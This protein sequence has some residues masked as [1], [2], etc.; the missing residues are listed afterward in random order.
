VASGREGE[1]VR[2]Y[3]EAAA[4]DFA[5]E[6]DYLVNCTG[7]DLLEQLRLLLPAAVRDELGRR[8]GGLWER[9]PAA[10]IPI[11][12]NLE[13]EG[14]CPRLHIPGLAGLSQG[15]G[16]AN[17]GSLGI[18]ANRVLEPLVCGAGPLVGSDDGRGAPLEARVPARADDPVAPVFTE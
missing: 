17:L 12:R 1:R 2:V 5:H 13:L 18:L 16:F 15:P 9:P 6:H 8:V 7:F 14:M 10:E 11:G 4:G 3:C